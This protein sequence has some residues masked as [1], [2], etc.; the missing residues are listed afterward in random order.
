MNTKQITDLFNKLGICP[1]YKGYP[2]LTYVVLTAVGYHGQPFPCLKNLYVTAG[3]H[4]GVSSSII[5]HDIRTLVRSYWN[6]DN[7]ATFSRV[8]HY[9]VRDKLTTKEF[10][11]IMAEYLASQA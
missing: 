2:Y 11:S 8:V 5:E 4:F 1:T 10:I 3:E 9:P 7:S 6:Q